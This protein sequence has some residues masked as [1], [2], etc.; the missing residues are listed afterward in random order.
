MNPE[1]ALSFLLYCGGVF[2]LCLGFM[3]ICSAIKLFKGR[4]Y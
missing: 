2:T 3:A 4:D 1:T